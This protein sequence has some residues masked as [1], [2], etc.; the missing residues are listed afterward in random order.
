MEGPMTT[1]TRALIEKITR[2]GVSQAQELVQ[3]LQ[4]QQRQ[5]LDFVAPTDTMQMKVT[6]KDGSQD[7]ELEF[8]EQKKG[9]ASEMISMPLTDWGHRQMAEKTGIPI[10]YYDR[11]KDEG[12]LDLVA[13]NVNRW[14]DTKEHRFIRTMGGKV[15]AI[16]S[17]K[18]L[19]LDHLKAIEHAATR[20][21]ELGATIANYV[22]TDTRL[23]VKMIDPHETWQIRNEDHHV[24]GIVFSNS[25]VGAGS[26]RAEAFV[27]R[28]ICKNGMIGMDKLARVHLGS[29][30]QPGMYVSNRTRD[31]EADLIGSKMQD[32]VETVF[33]R[34]KFDAWME[35]YR[36]TTDVK[37]RNPVDATKNVVNH[38]KLPETADA[39]L[40]NA[41]IGE[42][43]PTQYGLINALT[44]NAQ[45]ISDPEL[46]I[47]FEKVAGELS[48]ME[49]RE[50]QRTINKEIEVVA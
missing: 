39:N 43:D 32:I 9:M 28:L 41:L 48:V 26:F 11:M 2:T 50:F 40:L 27:M 24:R 49:E 42:G 33:D 19:V 6:E 29:K 4:E 25:E 8:E 38:F 47:R 13:E 46:S 44:N 31:L 17:D 3:T 16:L 22:M 20:A 5:K 36:M 35:Q 23:H 12:H 7:L 15:R 14:L 37:L 45:H 18:Y 21:S 30:M 34:Q 1:E 10:R